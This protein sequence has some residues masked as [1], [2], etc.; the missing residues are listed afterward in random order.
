MSFDINFQKGWSQVVNRVDVLNT[1]QYIDMRKEA[2]LN[3][4]LVPTID[5]APDLLVWDTTRYT[6]WQ[7]EIMGGTAHFTNVSCG[8]SGGNVLLQYLIR[9]TYRKEATI[10]PGSFSDQKASL[11]YNISSSSTNRKFNLQ[12]SGTYMSGNNQL[13]NWD[14]S[15]VSIFLPPNAPAKYHDD[16]T[17]NWMPD[18]LGNSSFINPFSNLLTRYKNNSDNL[19]GNLNLRYEILPGLNLQSSFGYNSLQTKET[20]VTP[21]SVTQPEYQTPGSRN[22]SY[23]NSKA[24]SWII[25]PQIHYERSVKRGRFDLL[26][27]GT[28]Q[29]N[30]ASNDV[31]AGIGYSR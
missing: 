30:I 15:E 6:N 23:G 12:F 11:H 27:G 26:L 18:S 10:F 9:G 2:F 22:A 7:D 17:L 20:L 13:P 19:I 5:N 29:H 28:I 25:E 24:E 1:Q 14:Y 31:I 4:G 3:D 16:G 8:V 21:L